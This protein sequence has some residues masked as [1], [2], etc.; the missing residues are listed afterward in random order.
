MKLESNGILIGLRA[1]NE[2]D[3]IA[4]VFT[5][6]FGVLVGMMR[7]ANVAKKNRPLV[8]QV[9]GAIWNARLD[10]QLGMF[11]WDAEKNLSASVMMN[12]DALM[13]LN[14]AFEILGTLLPEREEYSILYDETLVL[15]G[16]LACGDVGAYLTWEINLLRDLGYALD[17]SRC[18][19]C[20]A[21]E[22]LNYLSPRTGR[23]V[24]DTCAAP[25]VD[26]LYKLPVNLNTTLRFLENICMQQGVAVPQMRR[27]IKNV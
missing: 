3:A 11:H 25:Y 19:G 27:M 9:G 12:S 23:A 14:S 21:T 15:L 4:R 10:S 2:R 26:R 20:G 17:L 13:R 7:G 16:A 5:R 22:T 18:S 8:G 24:C 1:F 6:D